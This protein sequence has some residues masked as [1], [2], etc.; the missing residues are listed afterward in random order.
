[1][2]FTCIQRLEYPLT[3]S[4]FD[5]GVVGILEVLDSFSRFD[6]GDE[7]SDIVTRYGRH[8]ARRRMAALEPTAACFLVTK[9]GKATI[10]LVHPRE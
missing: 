3:H 1:M 2:C 4:S 9:R 6:R 10:L 7:R 5:G 8:T